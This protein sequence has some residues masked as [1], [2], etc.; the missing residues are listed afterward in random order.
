[1]NERA[2]AGRLYARRVTMARANAFVAQHHRHHKRVRGCVACLGAFDESG[3]L[4]GV[5]ILGQPVARMVDHELVV[6]VTRLATDGAANACSCLYGAT[7]RVARELGYLK[8]QTYILAEEPGTS[9]RASGWVKEADVR[10]KAW[11]HREGR[12]RRQ[13]Q[14]TGAKQRW[15]R[16]LRE[17]FPWER[18][19]APLE[20][21]R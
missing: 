10:A 13:D 16:V 6:E 14:P 2:D 17:P 7:A 19:E 20:V 3:K 8:V 12:V 15:A 21:A 1:M 11:P 5:A 18:R 4:R 9:L